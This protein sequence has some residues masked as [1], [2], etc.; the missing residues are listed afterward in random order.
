[1]T[2]PVTPLR[3]T[4]LALTTLILATAC[5]GAAGSGKSLAELKKEKD[6][7]TMNSENLET[8]TLGAG[9]FWC[10][11]AVL[12]RIKGVA[13]VQSG[14]MG[15]HVEGPTYRA[16]CTGETGHAEVVQVKFDPETLSF[17]K[18]LE[19]FWALHDP[20]TL[21]RQGND[22][23]TQYRSAIFYHSETQRSE[24][25]A[26]KAAFN[27]STFKGKIVTEIAEAS[28]FYPAEDYH[29]D[30]YNLN[31]SQPYCSFVIRPK[32]VKLGLE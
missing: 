8:A 31:G 11:E 18:L 25:E 26:S 16:V 14:Y 24:A 20:T 19:V 23:G 7:T 9:C 4:T 1:M 3:T 27:E 28:T 17:K 2:D 30:Y 10:V 29:Q 15:G 21:N 13:S 5:G 6:T 22:V 12:Q 32:L